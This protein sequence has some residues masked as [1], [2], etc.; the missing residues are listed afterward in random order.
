MIQTRQAP[1]SVLFLEL[2]EA[3][4]HFLKRYV[5]EGKLPRF[6]RMLEEGALV[7]TRVPQAHFTIVGSKP[8]PRVQALAAVEGVVVTGRV[9][10][11]REHLHRA[12][13][14]VV[15]F[16]SIL[17]LTYTLVGAAFLILAFCPQ[18]TT[19]FN[20]QQRFQFMKLGNFFG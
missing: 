14:S 13:V 18:W 4:Q 3:E 20:D 6:A 19:D 11:V 8:V 9:E 10:D 15:R 1:L 17:N 16:L 2:N 7:R 5:G 12:S